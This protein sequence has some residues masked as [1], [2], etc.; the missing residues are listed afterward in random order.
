MAAVSISFGPEVPGSRKEVF[1]TITFDSSYPTGGEGFTPAEFGLNRLDWLQLTNGQGY[2]P[3]WDGSTSAPKV[4]MYRQ[5]AAAG[6]LAETPNTTDL[7][8]ITVR[9]RATGA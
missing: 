3:L 5:G 2:V 6:A 9:F 8:A 1:G 7:S 4:L